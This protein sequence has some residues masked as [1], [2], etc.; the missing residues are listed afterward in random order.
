M[1]DDKL[2]L[3]GR[4]ES[5][6]DMQYSRRSQLKGSSIFGE[7]TLVGQ[8]KMV[9]LYSERWYSNTATITAASTSIGPVRAQLVRQL[10]S[11]LMLLQ[12]TAGANILRA[13]T[14]L[15]QLSSLRAGYAI[16]VAS[17]WT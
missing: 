5:H 17:K 12:I 11:S 2:Q 6:G 8:V 13:I 10:N 4:Q 7:L 1:L 9:L 16:D 14:Q 15:S 3:S